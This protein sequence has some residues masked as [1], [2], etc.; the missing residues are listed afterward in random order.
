MESE[1]SLPH[2]DGPVDHLRYGFQSLQHEMNERH[3]VQ[4]LQ[5][6]NDE[7]AFKDKLESAR[8]TYGSHMAMTLATEK[9]MMN[10]DHRLPGLKSSKIHLDTLLGDDCQIDFTDFLN[11][12]LIGELSI[13]FLSV[14]K[15][16]DPFFFSAV[17]TVLVCPQIRRQGQLFPRLVFT[18]PWRSK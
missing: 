1:Q 14:V 16:V 12:K 15:Y 6:A 2:Y 11:G 18:A 17:L 8:R 7:I 9:Q 3:P 4:M 10:R 5:R 13:L